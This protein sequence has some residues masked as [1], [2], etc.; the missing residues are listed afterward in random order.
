MISQLEHI[1]TIEK[2]LWSSTD[3]WREK[4]ATRNAAKVTTRDFLWDEAP[5]LPVDSHSEQE[6]KEK[7]DQ[8]YLHVFHMYSSADSLSSARM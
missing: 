4:E 6:V 5:S 8:L 7:A 1:E 2:R 3:N